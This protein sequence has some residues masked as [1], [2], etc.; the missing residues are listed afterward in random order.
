MKKP[1]HKCSEPLRE[2]SINKKDFME[3]NESLFPS[4]ALRPHDPI[5]TW[6]RRTFNRQNCRLT[7]TRGKNPFQ[8]EV[9]KY[10]GREK[11]LKETYMVTGR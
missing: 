5:P 4:K 8:L 10:G 1:S 6:K 11:A 2:S 3:N 9:T 7:Q